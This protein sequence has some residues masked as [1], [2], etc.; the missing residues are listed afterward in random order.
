MKRLGGRGTLGV[1]KQKL[2]YLVVTLASASAFSFAL[3][4]SAPA[5]VA[6]A[7]PEETS[8]SHHLGPSDTDSAA[9]SA[10]WSWPT[11]KPAEVARHFDPPAL[12]WLSG[13]RGA[14]LTAPVGSKVVSPAPGQVVFAGTVVDRHVVSVM[15]AGGLR[16]TYEPVDPSV[17][18][19]DRVE[20][21]TVLGVLES[22]H[23]PGDLHWG[24]RF[25]KNEYVNPLLLL[26]GPIVLKPWD[27]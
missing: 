9:R 20:T 17:S 5:P 19:G 6:A 23:S 26:M 7:L 22:G 1:M 21:G 2:G 12:P 18:Q 16:S 8:P 27:D 11:G 15:H 3:M 24:A 25:E 14:D 4:M 10:R 13:H